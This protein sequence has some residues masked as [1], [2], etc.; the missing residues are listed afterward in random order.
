LWTTNTS[1]NEL[2]FTDDEGTDHPLTGFV[3][4]KSYSMRSPT[5]SSGVYYQ[6]GYYEA[7]AAD[8]NLTQ[9]SLTQTMGT[10]N[11]SHAAHA[12]IVSAGDGATDGSDLVLTVT[13]TSITD[14]GVRTPAD[15]EIVVAD[16][17]VSGC[18]VDT[19]LETSK[20]WLGQI[21][22]T[23][24]STAGAT[25]AFSFNYGL[26]KYED[27]GNRTFMVTDFESVGLPDASDTGFNIEVLHHN[28]IGWVYSAGAFVAGNT[29][30]L[31]MNTIHGT[32]QDIIDGEPFAFK[33][34]GLTTEI[35]GSSSEGVVI[36]VTTGTNNALLYLDSH[37]GVV[38][39]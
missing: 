27:F 32:E 5:T 17:L 19:Y 11:A 1:P 26:C 37:I 33:A 36:R 6:A 34:A 15:S 28:D 18:P 29:A 21:T 25:F 12:F 14:A 9:A 7:P 10:A 20:K 3:S 35:D 31:N 22:Y 8:A 23:L 30:L 13:G 16:A 4:F 2:I 38:L 39:G 24:S